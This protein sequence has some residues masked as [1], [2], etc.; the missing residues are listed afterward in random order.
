MASRNF[1][2]S[3][4]LEKEVKSLYADVAIGA[5]GAPTVTKAL[6]IA[7]VVRNGAGD[8]TI[9]LD[10]KYVR[11]MHVDVQILAAS[12]EDITAQLAAEDVNGDKTIQVLTKAAATEA[13]PSDGARLLIRIDLK[14]STSGE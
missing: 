8:Y 7:S 13:D 6:G 12:A 4:A 5:S 10:D 11:L 1:N 2:R 9:T 14:N 3:Q